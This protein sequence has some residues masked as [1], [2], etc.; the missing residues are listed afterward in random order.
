M[1]NRTRK[2]LSEMQ[3]KLDLAIRRDAIGMLR[4]PETTHKVVAFLILANKAK[5][6]A[7]KAAEHAEKAAL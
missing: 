7:A 2:L 5:R 6:Y 1:A 3:G 4:E